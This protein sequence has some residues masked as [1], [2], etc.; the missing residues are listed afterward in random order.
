MRFDREAVFGLAQHFSLSSKSRD[1]IMQWV[2]GALRAHPLPNTLALLAIYLSH[3]ADIFHTLQDRDAAI[4]TFEE[5]RDLHEEMGN[6]TQAARCLQSLG[7][8]RRMQSNYGLAI[9]NLKEAQTMYENLDDRLGAAQC[10]RLLGDI[11]YIQSDHDASTTALTEARM[12][13]QDPLSTAQCLQYLWDICRDWATGIAHA[14]AR[15]Q[16]INERLGAT[17][18]LQFIGD[19]YRH[20]PNWENAT[21]SLTEAK[22]TFEALGNRAGVA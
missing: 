20:Q 6:T 3:L 5:S 7:D 22:A 1:D 14:R 12:A 18:C 11:Y 10:F 21:A 19:I 2:I 9:L 16:A 13:L 17:Q 4:A 8:I 15:Y